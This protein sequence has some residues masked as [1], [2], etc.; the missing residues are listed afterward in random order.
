MS[1]AK[2]LMVDWACKNFQSVNQPTIPA[3][4][5]NKVTAFSYIIASSFLFFSMYPTKHGLMRSTA[6]VSWITLNWDLI[7]SM[8]NRVSVNF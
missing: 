4:L 5:E 7:L 2:P 3:M 8:L 6:F 1:V